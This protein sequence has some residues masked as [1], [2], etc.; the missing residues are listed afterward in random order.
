MSVV[1]GVCGLAAVC[2]ASPTAASAQ[3]MALP[4]EAQWHLYDNIL[5][6]DRGFASR[7]DDGL[8]VGILYQSRFR[9]S[10]NAHDDLLRMGDEGPLRLGGHE[11]RFVSIEVTTQT[12]VSLRLD[13]EGV[14]VVYITPL[15]ASDPR[16]LAQL[17]AEHGIVS[18]T[19]VREYVTQGV[20]VGLGLRG[21]RPEILV[22]LTSCRA[23]GMELTAQLLH[24][25]TVIETPLPAPPKTR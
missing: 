17:A 9:V 22:N 13:Q 2:L 8:V 10:L 1:V 12:E 20:A 4:I 18:L 15:R 16:G 14:D 7:T 24:L 19:G 5:A 25:A 3:E 11:V 6:Y 23:Q 21:G